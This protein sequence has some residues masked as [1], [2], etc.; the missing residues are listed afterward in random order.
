MSENAKCPAESVVAENSWLGTPPAM[1]TVTPE[2]ISSASGWLLPV[3]SNST[4][5]LR[6]G[7]SVTGGVVVVVAGDEVVVTGG[8]VVVVDGVVVVVVGV[9]VVVV[10]VVVVVVGLTV[11]SASATPVDKLPSA[12]T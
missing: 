6:S 5:T 9:V 3:L 11:S 7:S 2:S 10:A 1:D 8:V 4:D 12:T